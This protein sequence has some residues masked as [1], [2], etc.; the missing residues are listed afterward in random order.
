MTSVSTYALTFFDYNISVLASVCI[1]F[2]N[3]TGQFFLSKWFYSASFLLKLQLWKKLTCI[4]NQC[5]KTLDF[6]KTL[7]LG[8][9]VN[10]TTRP[11][12]DWN[13]EL[14]T[15]INLNT[16]ILFGHLG[17]F[18]PNYQH[19]FWCNESLVY[20]FHYSTIISTKN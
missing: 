13:F 10:F 9:Y 2:L 11:K 3:P 15:I 6:L 5:V 16:F 17:Y 7:F 8:P 14:S 20:V 4:K 1:T 19:P 12:R 18:R